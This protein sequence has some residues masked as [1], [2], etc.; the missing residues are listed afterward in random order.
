MDDENYITFKIGSYLNKYYKI[1]S[2]DYIEEYSGKNLCT[3][4]D[5]HVKFERADT[6]YSHLQLEYH[7]LKMISPS[8]FYPKCYHYGPYEES[9]FLVTELLGPSLDQLLSLCGGKFTLKTVLQI[10]I[11]GL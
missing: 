4:Q 11:K 5:V 9:N 8:P 2:D 7:F 1:E 6:C 3:N 10:A